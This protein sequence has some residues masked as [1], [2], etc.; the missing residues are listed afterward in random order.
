MITLKADNRA[1]LRDAKFS[2]LLD[3]YASGISTII[4]ANTDGFAVNDYI[5]L[6]NIGSENTEIVQVATVTEATSTITLIAASRFAHSESTRVTKIGYNQVRFY[7]TALKTVPNPAVSPITV[8]TTVQNKSITTTETSTTTSPPTAVYTKTTDPTFTKNV[9]ITPPIIF[10]SSTPLGSLLDVDAD[11][12]FTTYADSAHSTGY[13]WFAFYN[14]T[15]LT[16]SAVSNAIP[17]GGFA[18]N[19]VREMFAG[20]DSCLNQKE[21]RLISSEDRYSWL[22]EGVARTVNE[23]NL[24]NWE[25]HS[26]G[27]INLAIQEG[28]SEYLLPEDFSALL[29]IN[30]TTDGRKI[31][32]YDQTFEQDPNMST[33]RYSIRGRY[34]TFL[35]SPEQAGSVT[36]A[37]LKMSSRLKELADVIDLPDHGYYMVKDFMLFRAYRKLSNL[38]ESNNSLALFNK[39]VENMKIYSIKR[40]NGL[41]SWTPAPETLV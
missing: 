6:G 19:T 40:D 31:L 4:V 9:D 29:Y 41:D 34:I 17:Y 22:N 38:T 8:N 28:V 16:Y 11:S 7:W 39:E 23:L 5:L 1:L 13:G 36:L 14:S 26:S 15:S 18:T 24:G 37:Y 12:F 33:R 3:N 2:Y 35:P 32:S 10:D 21:L 27:P 25:Y 20:F 30:E